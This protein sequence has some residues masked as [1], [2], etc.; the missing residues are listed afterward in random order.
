M[1]RWLKYESFKE[2]EVNI[3][4][5]PLEIVESANVKVSNIEQESTSSFS[6]Q[7]ETSLSP[8]SVKT[9]VKIR[10]FNESYLSLGFTSTG[11]EK[12]PDAMCLLCNKILVN[13]SLVPTKLRRHF[14]TNHPNCKDK[15][16]SFFKRK[17][18]DYVHSK[19]FMIKKFKT[20][21]DNAT[22][23]SYKVSYRIALAGEPHVIGETLIKNCVKDIVSCMFNVEVAKKSDAVDLSNNTASRRI[24]DIATDIENELIS[25]LKIC[26]AYTLQLDESRDVAGLAILLV[27]VRALVTKNMSSTLK[28]VLD[29]AV[30]II[31]FI[32]SQALQSRNFTALCEDMGSI[33]TTLLLHTKVRWL[34]RGKIVVRLS[35]LR[36]ELLVYFAEHKF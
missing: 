13:S 24:K 33:H 11:S 2:P 9:S 36:Q 30:K 4:N 8:C 23:A 26:D 34:S 22:L 15:D 12:V 7:Q 6:E 21:N 28:K 17:Y 19:N 16:I 20:D 5:K 29:E 32:K 14:E 31:N 27:F 3:P 25:R 10:K 35:E 1:D 18:E